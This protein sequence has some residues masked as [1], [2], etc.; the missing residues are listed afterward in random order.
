[1]I[2]LVGP[3]SGGNNSSIVRSMQSIQ[4]ICSQHR[5]REA[6][7]SVSNSWVRMV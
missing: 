1:M 7:G 4:E 5:Q 6:E 3:T 2:C